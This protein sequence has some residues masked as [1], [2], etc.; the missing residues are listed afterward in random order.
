LKKEPRVNGIGCA[1]VR[2]A[3]SNRQE[4]GRSVTLSNSFAPFIATLSLCALHG[5]ASAQGHLLANGGRSDYVIVVADDASPSVAYAAE[6]LQRFLREMTGAT[7]PIVSD[8]QPMV[9]LEIIIGRNAHLDRVSV[10]IPFE[11]LGD[12]GYV[13]KSS[14]NRIVVVGSDVRGTLYGVYGLLQDHLGCRWF[15][16]EV[17]RI[18]KVDSL[19]IRELDEVVLPVLEYRWPAV[20]D[21][22]DGDWCARNRVN[23]GPELAPKHGGSVTFHGWVHTFAELVPVDRYFDAH[24]EYFS[25]IDGQRRRNRTQLCCTN[26]D[27]IRIVTEEVRRR[28]REHPEAF[29]YSV[30]QNDYGNYCECKSC[31][32]L[33]AQEESQMGPVLHLVNRVA[34][35]V[36]QEFPDKVIETLAYQWS[37][38]PPRTMRPRPNVIIRLCSIECCFAHPFDECDYPANIEFRRDVVD[39]SGIC[40][41][42][43]IWNYTTNFR[44]YYLPHPTLRALKDDIVFFIDHNVKGIYEQDTKLTLNGDMSPLG[45]YMMAQFLWNPGYDEDT[46]VNEFLE[47]V[48][49]AGARYIRQYID[50]LHDKVEG[51]TI[52]VR[53]YE[54][55]GEAYLTEAI[56][57]R[58]DALWEQALCAVEDDPACRERVEFGRLCIDYAVIEHARRTP[59]TRIQ[60]KRAAR[61][62]K[63]ER[64]ARI[65]RFFGVAERAGVLTLAE[66]KRSLADYRK[67]LEKWQRAE[68][69]E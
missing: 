8:S 55:T 30:S 48:Y 18:P 26:E 57:G 7:L 32:A 19:A 35:A 12:E 16:P 44:N 6:E 20:M 59:S 67:E 54:N 15:T 14:G 51:E 1:R 50:L 21:C 22:Y 68:A 61:E 47:A 24:P 43:W 25:E 34:E 33:A 66:G 39:W 36:E 69:T 29:A 4:G 60:S 31:Q 46:A 2:M 62:Q 37:R 28:M 41:R 17:S 9:P 5:L 42:L 63:E 53:C 65:E 13:L 64:T 49:G 56:L 58:A 52:H 45:G 40:D 10:G 23:V 38:R 27:V 3:T 11:R